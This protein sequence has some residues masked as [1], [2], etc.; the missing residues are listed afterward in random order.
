MFLSVNQLLMDLMKSWKSSY[1]SV[2]FQSNVGVTRRVEWL[3]AS[4]LRAAVS[5]AKLSAGCGG[6][7]MTAKS[8][9]SYQFV[10]LGLLMIS[11]LAVFLSQDPELP[12]CRFGLATGMWT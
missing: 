10:Y 1:C 12:M 4:A 11:R 5:D 8:I 6:S 9:Q 2:E 3:S 7:F